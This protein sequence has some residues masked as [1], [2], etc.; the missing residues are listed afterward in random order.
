VGGGG[1]PLFELGEI[2]F[3]TIFGNFC[4]YYGFK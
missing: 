3:S 2:I 4:S 1:Y